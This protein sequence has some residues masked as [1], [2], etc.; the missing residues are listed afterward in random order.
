MPAFRVVVIGDSLAFGQGVRE[1]ETLAG[2][3]STRLRQKLSAQVEVINLGV[4]G[5]NT[6]QEYWTF[7]ERALPL[8]PQVCLLLYCA[9]DTDP[10]PFQIKDN[11]VMS[12]DLRTGIGGDFH[13]LARKKSALY[14]L[15]WMRWHMLKHGHRVAIKRYREE[16][17]MKF[18]EANPGW[19]K[20][21]SSLVDLISLARA[22]SIRTIVIPYPLPS[23]LR[24][25]PYPFQFYINAAFET[26]KAAGA[27]CLDVIPMLQ[28]PSI[29]LTV[30][31][32]EPHPSA[33]VYARIAEELEKMLR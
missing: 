4:P 11:A 8:K 16:L 23:G 25:K 7:K 30:G 19:K 27:E 3:L 32:V 10:P 9:N 22:R 26:A 15:V 14:N 21:Q 28:D 31:P 5:Y 20:S 24:E 18:A 6:T 12:P 13:N 33:Q 29:R 2:Q 1:Q 17:T